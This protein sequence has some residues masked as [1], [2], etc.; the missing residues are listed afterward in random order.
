[1]SSYTLG[2]ADTGKAIVLHPT[3]MPWL[4]NMAKVFERVRWLSAVIEYR[5]LVGANTAGSVAIGF[6]WMA[7]SSKVEFRDGIHVL[8]AVIDKARVLACT[9]SMDSPLWQRVPAFTLPSNRLQSRLWYELEA[10]NSSNTMD[11]APGSLLVFNTGASSAAA[12]EV[13]VRYR[14]HFSGTRVA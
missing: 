11:V 3:N 2:T 4:M 1:M 5:P 10:P 14:V 6:D 7:P 8:D 13:W 9:P 12:G